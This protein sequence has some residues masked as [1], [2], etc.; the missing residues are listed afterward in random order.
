MIME[1]LVSIIV[2]VYKSKPYLERCVQSVMKQTYTCWELLLVDDGSPDDSGVLCDELA[3]KDK[4]IRAIHKD[5][6]GVSSARNL[7]IWESKGEWMMFLDSDDFFKEEDY[8]EQLMAISY[9]TDIVISGFCY[10]SNIH[11]YS[12]ARI[13]SQEK[14][15]SA[16]DYSQFVSENLNRFDFLVVW[17]KLFKSQIIQ[18]HHLQF[19]EKMIVAEDALFLHQY[20][21]WCHSLSV[22]SMTGYAFS[23]KEGKSRYKLTSLQADYHMKTI[24]ADLKILE[25]Q[26]G[27]VNKKYRNYIPVYFCRLYAKHI[28]FNNLWKKESKENLKRILK[29]PFVRKSLESNL[30]LRMFYR[31]LPI[32]FHLWCL[33]FHVR[34]RLK[35]TPAIYSPNV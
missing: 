5:N 6:G 35:F 1:Q 20:L 15:Y 25:E 21:L 13:T 27:I 32:R 31:L 33:D 8:I 11:G 28:W 12:M 22:S 19:N 34:C 24:M 29:S 30:L 17:A 9:N 2:P 16:N 23:T 4:R 7:G 14:R 26:R 3:A 18:N 10:Y